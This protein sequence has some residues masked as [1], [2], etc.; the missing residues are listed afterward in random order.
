MISQ[1]INNIIE[2]LHAGLFYYYKYITINYTILFHLFQLYTY[3]GGS[4]V[5]GRTHRPVSG[6]GRESD[7]PPTPFPLTTWVVSGI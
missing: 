5:S 4:V 2:M 6:K 3:R 7:Y 1:M